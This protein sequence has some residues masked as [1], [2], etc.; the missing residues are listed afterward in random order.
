MSINDGNKWSVSYLSWHQ[1]LTIST[2]DKPASVTSYTMLNPIALVL[3]SHWSSMKAKNLSYNSVN[4]LIGLKSRH[5]TYR[6]RRPFSIEWG[7]NLIN[8]T[9]N[10]T[11]RL[12]V[13]LIDSTPHLHWLINNYPS[14]L[15]HI[16][17]HIR[18]RRIHAENVR[19][20]NYSIQALFSISRYL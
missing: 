20:L 13:S 3:F 18:I 9:R 4:S 7:K 15:G 6:T 1:V 2:F 11:S 19:K 14:Y 8:I 17:T 16:R 5:L 12:V 10:W